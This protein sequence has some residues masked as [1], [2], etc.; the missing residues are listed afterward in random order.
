[1]CSWNISHSK[2]PTE[3]VCWIMNGIFFMNCVKCSDVSLLPSKSI[4]SKE[5]IL[6]E[7]DLSL[8]NTDLIRLMFK[9]EKLNDNDNLE[10]YDINEGDELK[11]YLIKV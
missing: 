1:M 3:S 11:Y 9:N 10:A 6:G 2:L 8:I 5:K 7:F 4:Y